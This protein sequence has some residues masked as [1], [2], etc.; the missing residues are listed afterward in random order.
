M[1]C[2]EC[3][4][5]LQSRHQ[6]K[7]CSKVCAAIYN[8]RLK[9][10][11]AHWLK[12][13]SVCGE[14]FSV[15]K[16]RNRQYCSKECST[17]AQIKLEQ[18][19]HCAYCGKE[20][21]RKSRQFC[22][23][24][25]YRHFRYEKSARFCIDCGKPLSGNSTRTNVRC[26]TCMHKYNFE[27][28]SKETWGGDKQIVRRYVRKLIRDLG[29]EKKCAICG[30]DN[31]LELCHIK[32]VY[33]FPPEATLAEINAPSNLVYLCPNHHKELDN[34]ILVLY[35]NWQREQFQTLYSLSSNLRGITLTDLQVSAFDL[36]CSTV[37]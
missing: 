24:E 28:R 32:P 16:S 19:T 5:E 33:T 7:F 21:V 11:Q 27:E 17:Q 2:L 37:R 8:N 12:I 3:G 31:Y 34:G 35:P 6:K 26:V 15:S 10:K 36:L 18:Y 25:C 23:Q 14:E 4:N 1:N 20:L 22:S 13:C 30:Y 29:W 9:S